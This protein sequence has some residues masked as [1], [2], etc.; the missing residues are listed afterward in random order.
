MVK[1]GYPYGLGKCRDFNMDEVFGMEAGRESELKREM[2]MNLI[3][4][5]SG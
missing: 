5:H 4:R 3:S 2:S 1:K